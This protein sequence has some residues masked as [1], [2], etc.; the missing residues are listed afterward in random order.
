MRERSAILSLAIFFLFAVGQADGT[1]I[2]FE[3]KA[4]YQPS[5]PVFFYRGKAGFNLL[6]RVHNDGPGVVHLVEANAVGVGSNPDDLE[7]KEVARLRPGETVDLVLSSEELVFWLRHGDRSRGW[8][9]FLGYLRA[10]DY[11]KVESKQQADDTDSVKEE[12]EK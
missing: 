1:R 7:G 10:P 6:Y 12:G 5:D 9:Q 11:L 8:Y 2:D 3:L 4:R